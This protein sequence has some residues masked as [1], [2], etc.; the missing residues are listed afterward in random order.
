[1]EL[2][3]ATNDSIDK[4][5]DYNIIESLIIQHRNVKMKVLHDIQKSIA[6][7]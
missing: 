6:F 4:R 3:C 7:N 2:E 1:M 5:S